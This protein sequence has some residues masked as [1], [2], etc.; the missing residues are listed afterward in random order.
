MTT[1]T[2]GQIILQQLGGNKFIAMTGAKMFVQS[3]NSLQ[4]RI[5]KF[6]G[7]KVN[8]VKIILEPS[9]TYRVQFM[10]IRGTTFETIA[11]REDIYA[12]NLKDVFTRVT[13]LRTS[14]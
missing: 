11:E 14:L 2:V 12:E 9:D 3:D 10:K 5:P 13:G 6:P 4:F 7:V 1:Q 8:F